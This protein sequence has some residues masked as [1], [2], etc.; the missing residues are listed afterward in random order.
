MREFTIEGMR[1][2]GGNLAKLCDELFA[3]EYTY[4]NPQKISKQQVLELMQKL[5]KE[6]YKGLNKENADTSV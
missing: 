6:V 1:E 3:R 5:H 2:D 4:F